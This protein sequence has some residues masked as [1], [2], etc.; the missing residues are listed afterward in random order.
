M[1]IIDVVI[2]VLA[3]AALVRGAR[4]G[5][6]RQIFST[7]GF[8][9]GLF[10]GA[11]L[12]PHFTHFMHSQLSKS[13][14]AIGLTLGL[15]I[16]LMAIA[17][18]FG[19]QL[20]YSMQKHQINR[21]DS[22]LGAV[23]G[24]ATLLLSVWLAAAL[25]VTLPVSG[26]QDNIRSSVI[27]SKLT[28]TLPPAPH[29]IADLGRLI[30]PNGFPQVFSG[31]EP[32]PMFAKLPSTTSLLPAVSHDELSVVKI[33]G[34][35]CGGIIEGSGFVVAPGLVATNAHVVAGVARPHVLDQ[36]G[37]HHAMA[38]WFEPNLDFAVLRVDNLSEPPLTLHTKIADRG[39]AASALGYPGGGDFSAQPA[40]ILDD[41]TATGRNIYNQGAP[42][43]DIYEVQSHIIPGNSGGPLIIGDGSVIGIVFAQSTTYNNVGYAITLGKVSS[44]INQAEAQNTPVSTGTCA[45]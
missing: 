5:S 29:I 34:N 24:L 18:Y 28:K 3:L 25:I 16:V 37:S 33:E 12:E 14:L 20:K 38:I 7:G 32:T 36:N 17:E 42:D 31:V 23:V 4:V 19:A 26:A 27:I 8:L 9:V 10:A 2:I 13:L 11:W 21:I 35:G 30:N 6:V 45:N 15:A 22:A 41:F 1:N 39:T 43:R 40:V 44:E